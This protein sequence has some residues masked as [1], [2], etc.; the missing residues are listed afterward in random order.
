MAKIQFGSGVAAISGRTAGTVFSRNKGGAYMRR[1]SIPTNPQTSKQD[2]ARN[3][4][5]TASAA[6]RNLTQPQRDAWSAWALTHPVVDRLGASIVLTGHQAFVKIRTNA[7]IVGDATITVSPPADPTFKNPV[8]NGV[9]G[10]DIS[11]E[12]VNV[13]V[14]VA[15]A[16]GDVLA[17][18][19]TPPVSPGVT[20]AA[21]QERL[22]AIITIGNGGLAKDATIDL[23]DEYA[24]VF[25]ALN[26]ALG[27][28][29]MARGYFYSKGQFGQPSQAQ[30]IVAA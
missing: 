24:E 14:G 12:E 6:W 19:A 29:V 30:G 21:A 20:N 28:K 10:L 5:S 25:G 2:Q 17:I 13:G 4:L 23:S 27:K 22:V 16:E 18:Y 3:R 9:V 11:E 26:G 8:L 1:F 15:L 7:A